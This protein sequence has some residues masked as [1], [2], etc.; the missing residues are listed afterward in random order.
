MARQRKVTAEQLPGPD[1]QQ[2]IRG[3]G[4]PDMERK[5]STYDAPSRPHD[6]MP[7]EAAQRDRRKTKEPPGA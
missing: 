7:G 6:L 3:T 2:P 4:I 5:G 1:E